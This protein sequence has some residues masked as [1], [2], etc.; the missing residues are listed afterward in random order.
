MDADTYL[1]EFQRIYNRMYSRYYRMGSWKS[2]R[3]TNKMTKAE[4][5]AWTDVASKARQEYKLDEI[6]GGEILKQISED[7][8]RHSK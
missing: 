7:I 3:S 6:S 2:S 8:K 5:K 4:S 1:Q